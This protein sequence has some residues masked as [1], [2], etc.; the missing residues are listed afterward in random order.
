MD[1]EQFDD[2]VDDATHAV[3][4]SLPIEIREAHQKLGSATDRLHR[5]NDALTLILR[6]IVDIVEA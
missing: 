3:W 5:I 4:A 2:M 6:D 1:D